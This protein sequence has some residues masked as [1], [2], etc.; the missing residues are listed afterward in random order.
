MQPHKASSLIIAPIS[1]LS[2]HKRLEL[3]AQQYWWRL[4]GAF[5][6]DFSTV[7][8]VL[9]QS[10]YRRYRDTYL[11]KY[12]SISFSLRNLGARFPHFLAQHRGSP[13]SKLELAHDCALFDWARVEAFDAAELP[14]LS[15]A[16]IQSRSF[17]NKKLFLQPHVQLLALK[18]PVNLL[19]TE[20]RGRVAEAASNTL[21]R[22][23]QVGKSL[24]QR[25]VPRERTYLAIHR[26]EERVLMKCVSQ[27]TLQI[28][29][30]FRA[31]CSLAEMFDR[32]AIRL[33]PET[34]HQVFS[35]AASLGW[36]ST[37]KSQ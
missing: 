10:A 25:T 4:Q 15:L 8:K 24:S 20:G 23:R 1:K 30:Y 17:A 26:K 35:E 3:Y 37:K 5:D 16:E 13:R 28:L 12:P 2:A 7:R 34:I 36:L 11:E 21:R 18:H 33:K 9:S 6:E 27:E 19:V 32:M 14:P 22:K 31:G 29:D